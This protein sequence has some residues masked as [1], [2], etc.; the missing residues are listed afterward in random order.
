MVIK[1]DTANLYHKRNEM[2]V[3]ELIT[4]LVWNLS[5]WFESVIIIFEICVT[6]QFSKMLLECNRYLLKWE[7]MIGNILRIYKNTFRQ[8]MESLWV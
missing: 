6:I 4:N 3:S 2:I 8:V 1:L 5:M 7:K